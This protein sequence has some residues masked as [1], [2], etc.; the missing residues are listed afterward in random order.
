MLLRKVLEYM[1]YW[2]ITL[3][4]EILIQMIMELYLIQYL[5]LLAPL[6]IKNGWQK[7]PVLVLSMALPVK[8]IYILRNGLLI[9]KLR[10]VI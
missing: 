9:L 3:K 7:N 2:K 5:L 10:M 8:L 6:V 4:V 1:V